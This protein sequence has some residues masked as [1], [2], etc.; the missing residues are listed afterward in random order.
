MRY[1]ALVILIMLLI[2]LVG[3]KFN[4][5]YTYLECLFFTLCFLVANVLMCFIVLIFIKYW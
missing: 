5:N 2:A 3:K 4:K 1:V